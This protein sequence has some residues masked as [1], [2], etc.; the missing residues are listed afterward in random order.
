MKKVILGV[1]GC[2]FLL[3]A[4]SALVV[5]EEMNAK[6]S[7][8]TLADG[9]KESVGNVEFASPKP[10]SQGNRLFADPLSPEREAFIKRFGEKLTALKE[11]ASSGNKWVTKLTRAW[12]DKTV[13]AIKTEAKKDEEEIDADIDAYMQSKTAIA[14]AQGLATVFN[15]IDTFLS[16]YD[17]PYMCVQAAMP[18]LG[19]VLQTLVFSNEKNEGTWGPKDPIGQAEFIAEFN[20]QQQEDKNPSALLSALKL[21]AKFKK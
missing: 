10:A 12:I 7:Q 11:E 9:L 2:M 16:T 14:G 5:A 6:F 1:G 15:V 20:E 3:L 13:K 21:T 17:I 8:I 18:I 4:P 19:G